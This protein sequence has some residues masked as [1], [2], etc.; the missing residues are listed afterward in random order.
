MPTIRALFTRHGLRCTRQRET[1]YGALKDTK[2]HPTPEQLHAL[3]GDADPGI[4][5]ATVYNTLDAL[6][7]AG[8]CRRYACESGR[9]AYRYDADVESHAHLETTDGRLLDLPDA[10]GEELLDAIPAELLWRIE[11]VMG[12]DIDRV[13]LRLIASDDPDTG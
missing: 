2:R 6:C 9:N 8:L 13:S 11:H 5:L 7:D 10:L 1:I 4:S 12:V 3:V